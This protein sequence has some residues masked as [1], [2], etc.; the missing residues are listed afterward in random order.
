MPAPSPCSCSLLPHIPS[1]PGRTQHTQPCTCLLQTHGGPCLA[2]HT[3]REAGESEN[4]AWCRQAPRL[5]RKG[6]AGHGLGLGAKGYWSV[7]GATREEGVPPLPSTKHHVPGVTP[8][9]GRG[10]SSLGGRHMVQCGARGQ[11]RTGPH[12]QQAADLGRRSE[13]TSRTRLPPE[14][15]TQL[16]PRPTM[17]R[18]APC[19]VRASLTHN[20]SLALAQP[21]AGQAPAGAQEPGPQGGW[22]SGGTG[23][24]RA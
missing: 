4:R 15:P 2:G 9:D 11:V 22:R 19:L 12:R 10:A 1:Q 17:A 14:L 23:R 21:R 18:R 16:P 8:E 13:A 5:D 3:W 24:G 20:V 7:V 6:R